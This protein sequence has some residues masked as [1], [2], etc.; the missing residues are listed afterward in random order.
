MSKRIT[1]ADLEKENLELKE[2]LKKFMD[3]GKTAV[4]EALEQDPCSD[5]KEIIYNFCEATGIDIPTRRVEYKVTIEVPMNEDSSDVCDEIKLVNKY[6]SDVE[7]NMDS[8][9]EV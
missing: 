9:Y 8:I 7:Y 1:K 5:S 6:N 4:D 2:R 3:A